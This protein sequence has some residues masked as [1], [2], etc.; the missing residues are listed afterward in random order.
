MSPKLLLRDAAISDQ[1][2][3]G[4]IGEL[5]TDTEVRSLYLPRRTNSIAMAEGH[6]VRNLR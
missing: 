6:L 2:L 4:R 1:E 3:N 5:D